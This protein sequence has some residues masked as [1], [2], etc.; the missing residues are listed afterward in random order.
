[1]DFVQQLLACTALCAPS[2]DVK[3]NGRTFKIVRLLGEGGFAFVY[4]AE[5]TSSG[6]Q[7]ALKKIRCQSSEGYRIA[8]KEVEAYKRFRHPYCIRC[9]DSCVIQDEEGQVIYLFLPFYKRG[10]LQD[11][12]NDHVTSGSRFG[13]RE[14]LRL[15][16][17]T[18]EAV[19]AMHTYVPGSSGTAQLAQDESTY[20]PPQQ[21][22]SRMRVPSAH[23]L[24]ETLDGGEDDEQ[25]A[26]LIRTSEM[27][28]GILESNNAPEASTSAV[29]QLSDQGDTL[30]SLDPK[31]APNLNSTGA[32]QRG[33]MTPWAHRDIKPANIMVTDDGQDAILMDFGSAAP[34]RVEVPSR[35]VALTQQDLAAEQCSMPFRA[36]ELFDVKTG[37]DLDQKVDIWSLGC[38][39]FALAFHHSPF[40]T[41]QEQQGGSIAMAVLNGQYKF[42]SGS[43]D[44]YS[45]PLKD[46]IS[47]M[48]IVDP[49]S[50]PDIHQV[51]TS[52]KAALARNEQVS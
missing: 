33:K 5:D 42:P 50:R 36:P 29:A 20:P 45:Q 28:G 49:E 37:Q 18:C 41:E 21:R 6:R 9:L 2:K 13:E 15:F 44:K 48:L 16:L 24:E 35:S 10:N 30:G 31:P 51:I 12:I 4:L 46:L 43:G 17:K 3:L 38:T 34:A 7:F 25:D 40:E 23:S 52:T 8:M 14:M 39:L 47:S 1:M 26:P 27:S 11:A 32:K 22:V 19:R